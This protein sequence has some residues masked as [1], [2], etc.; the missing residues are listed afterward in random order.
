MAQFVTGKQLLEELHNSKMTYCAFTDAS[1]PTHFVD[2]LNDA[3][4]AP[5]GSIVRVSTYEHIPI[6][7]TCARV[8]PNT[9]QRHPTLMFPPFKHYQRVDGEWHEVLRSHWVGDLTGGHYSN[10]HGRISDRL[11]RYFMLMI[12]K[13]A[14]SG[15]FSGYSYRDEM[16]SEAAINLMWRG[17]S[18]N[19]AKSNNPFAYYTCAID[20]SFKRILKNEKKQ[21]T[22][23]DDVLF[24]A[25]LKPSFGAQEVK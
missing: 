15:K 1:K 12:E 17:L 23:R 3:S 21:Q 22:I 4:D 25:G 8:N 11:A 20:N 5:D 9:R 2:D 7:P 18:F 19:E 10:T 16:I 24:N 6:D 13:R 14:M